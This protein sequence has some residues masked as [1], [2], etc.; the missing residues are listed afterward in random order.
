MILNTEPGAYWLWMVRLR[1]GW[2]G[3][4]TTASQAARSMVPVKRSMS[5]A[6]VDTMASTS[7][8]RGIHDHHRARV[9]VHGPLGRL[10]DAAIDGGDHLRARRRL[11]ALDDAELAARGVDLDALAAVLAAQVVVEEPLESRLPHHVA[12]PVAPLAQ[13]LLAHLPH[14]AEEVGG[15]PAGGIDALGLDLDDHARQLELP[16]LDLGHVLQG[17]TPAHAHGRD[18]V[19]RHTRATASTSSR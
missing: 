3:S 13:L 9:A 11:R 18:G 2:A 6:G 8:L 10:L 12:A 1:S 15:E 17:Q 19:G 14:V 4:F 16:L 5:N 7:P